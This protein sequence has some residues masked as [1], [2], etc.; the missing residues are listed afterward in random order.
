[1][2]SRA[3][4]F[5]TGVK[6]WK[7]PSRKLFAVNKQEL[8]GK[9]TFVQNTTANSQE[10][11]VITQSS[12]EQQ[13]VVEELKSMKKS[14]EDMQLA[15]WANSGAMPITFKT[16]AEDAFRCKICHTAPCIPPVILA[17]CCTNIVGCQTCVDQWFT[18]ADGLSKNC[19]ICQQARGYAQTARLHG[20]DDFIE[21]VR[22]LGSQ[23]PEP[24][25]VAGSRSS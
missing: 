3:L 23:N 1:M 9:A 2:I 21:E 22:K 7:T 17:R 6:F 5:L 19:P 14:I 20:L 10:S 15:I 25:Q 16:G 11:T 4:H 24:E 18:G 13:Q 8:R 12:S